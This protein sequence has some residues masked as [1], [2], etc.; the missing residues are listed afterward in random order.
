MT[1][2]DAVDGLTNFIERPRRFLRLD[3]QINA[4][5][6]VGPD[7]RVEALIHLHHQHARWHIAIPYSPLKKWGHKCLETAN[8]ALDHPDARRMI[9]R[10]QPL[11]HSIKLGSAERKLPANRPQ[12]PPSGDRFRNQLVTFLERCVGHVCFSAAPPAV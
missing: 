11:E 4:L 6:G 10:P 12:T 3:S 2:G 8:V 9:H 7:E 1:A 5:R